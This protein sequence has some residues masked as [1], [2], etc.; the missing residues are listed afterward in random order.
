[1]FDSLHH[2]QRSGELARA[3]PGRRDGI[4]GRLALTLGQAAERVVDERQP[5]LVGQV[6]GPQLAHQRIGRHADL[7]RE[8]VNGR[9]DQIVERFELG[10]R[11]QRRVGRRR[12]Q[13][14][15]VFH[16]HLKRRHRD[17]AGNQ[18]INFNI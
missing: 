13:Q 2:F 1:M 15:P 18:K 14:Q 3:G 16:V 12:A 11:A 6:L 9:D 17:N 7:G 4:D 5:L 10:A 8:A